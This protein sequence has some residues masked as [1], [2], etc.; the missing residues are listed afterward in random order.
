MVFEVSSPQGGQEDR[1]WLYVFEYLPAKS[2]KEL[3]LTCKRFTE[4]LR[5]RTV[6]LKIQCRW[7]EYLLYQRDDDSTASASS[8]SDNNCD[9]DVDWNCLCP[10]LCVNLM[11][12]IFALFFLGMSIG[13]GLYIGPY[14]CFG[15]KNPTC[16][17]KVDNAQMF[18]VWPWTNY[19]DEQNH[20]YSCD[21][22][23]ILE[24]QT[25]LLLQ[26]TK[27]G[28][29]PNTPTCDQLI[30]NNTYPIIK[31]NGTDNYHLALDDDYLW[32]F[33]EHISSM[34]KTMTG[35]FTTASAVLIISVAITS[36]GFRKWKKW[37]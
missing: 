6:E 20:P 16:F 4:F 15:V 12:I 25:H 29:W 14:N 8:S 28:P 30:I 13:A 1:W 22:E 18:A 36:C 3:G 34:C 32:E 26:R 11:L 9:G 31:I 19:N 17:D 35:I 7:D 5:S 23:L 2:Q 27:P 21:F 37:Y 24:N 33:K 10:R